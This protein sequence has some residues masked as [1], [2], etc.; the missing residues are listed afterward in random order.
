MTRSAIQ[1]SAHPV[2]RTTGHRPPPP[3][4]CT[5]STSMHLPIPARR[6]GLL[7]AATTAQSPRSKAA[8]IG[9]Y[10]VSRDV[11]AV[12]VGKERPL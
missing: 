5:Q 7:C 9:G 6:N 1:R 12:T 8:Q 3:T 2:S 11:G 4:Q 10:C